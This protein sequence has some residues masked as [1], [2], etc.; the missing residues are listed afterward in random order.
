[1][2]L[3]VAAA[4]VSFFLHVADEGFDGGASPELAFDDAE[5]AAARAFVSG[6][7]GISASPMA[8]GRVKGSTYSLPRILRRRPWLTS[9][10]AIGK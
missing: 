7:A 8:N 5:D 3:E 6:I 4:E 2:A 1:M 10:A 9:T